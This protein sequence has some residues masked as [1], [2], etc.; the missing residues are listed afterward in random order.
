MAEKMLYALARYDEPSQTRFEACREALV[1][2]GLVGLQT[3][4][5]PHHLTLASFAVEEEAAVRETLL[6]QARALAPIDLRIA[7]I[8][9]FGLRVLFLSPAP[10]ERLTRLAHDLSPDDGWCAHTT[11]LIDERE[12]IL[13]AIPLLADA[14]APFDARIAG[15]DLY[16]FFPSRHI[17]YYPLSK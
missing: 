13:R 15:I 9:L 12:P 2:A 11:M 14:F 8:G 1:S 3:R 17:A 6:T 16:E 10:N 5:L 4:G 7:S